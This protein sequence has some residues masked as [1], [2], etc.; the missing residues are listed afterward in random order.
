MKLMAF[1]AYY[2]LMHIYVNFTWNLKDFD[3]PF[4]EKQ[5]RQIRAEIKNINSYQTYHEDES[6]N[7]PNK[8]W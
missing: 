7:Y 1:D 6:K 3:I 2:K 8:K 5:L 4:L